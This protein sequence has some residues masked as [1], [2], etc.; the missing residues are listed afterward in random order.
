[1]ACCYI[2]LIPDDLKINCGNNNACKQLNIFLD[3]LKEDGEQKFGM[4][5]NYNFPFEYFEIDDFHDGIYDYILKKEYTVI[6][7]RV[8]CDF[9]DTIINLNAPKIKERINK[10]NENKK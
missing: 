2:V 1:M 8:G 6:I 10:I 7:K 5:A 4:C 9:P 3:K